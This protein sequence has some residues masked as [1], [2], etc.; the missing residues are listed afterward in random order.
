M[1][2]W[3]CPV[4][5]P[6]GQP[7]SRFRT[8]GTTCDPGQGAE[9]EA[10]LPDHGGGKARPVGTSVSALCVL[11]SWPAEGS[12]TPLQDVA[13][14]GQQAGD[15][16]RG[17]VRG[18]SVGPPDHRCGLPLQP[19]SRI[20]DTVDPKPGACRPPL[21]GSAR[22]ADRRFDVGYVCSTRHT[23]AETLR[24]DTARQGDPAGRLLSPRPSGTWRA[25]LSLPPTKS[26]TRPPQ[27]RPDSGRI[28]AKSS[29]SL[30]LLV[31]RGTVSR[32]GEVLSCKELWRPVWR[33]FETSLE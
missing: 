25:G 11:G 9:S 23:G 19:D 6:T 15:D 30:R 16:G 10:A 18:F 7:G 26:V 24:A 29:L 3:R 1:A 5:A 33:G 28:D 8:P 27:F 32:I 2:E 31:P 22:T 4:H 13:G 21:Y 20:R 14:C 17:G 12:R